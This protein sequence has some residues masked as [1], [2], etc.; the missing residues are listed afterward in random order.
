M[1]FSIRLTPEEKSLAESYAK[2]RPYL[3]EKP[4]RKHCSNKSRKNTTLPL[5]KMLT[6]NTS[7]TARKAVLFRNCGRTWTYDLSSRNNDPV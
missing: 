4:S 5:P 6:K 3:W 2:L 7:E 1:S